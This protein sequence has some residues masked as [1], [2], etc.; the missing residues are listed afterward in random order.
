M[1]NNGNTA[2][3]P[4][5]APPS[6][7]SNPPFQQSIYSRYVPYDAHTNSA[8]P[9]PSP[10]V[11]QQP[12]SLL[13]PGVA[14]GGVNIVAP[15]PTL[16]AGGGGGSQKLL[17]NKTLPIHAE[18]S[19]AAPQ[20]QPIVTSTSAVF[21]NSGRGSTG[22]PMVHVFNPSTDCSVIDASSASGSVL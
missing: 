3:P 19:V 21:A 13:S 22:G 12:P 9:I 5:F 14:P 17:G 10:L 4:T 1:F 11:M 15:S 18:G 20:Q 7:G 6:S 2:S 16:A 8:G